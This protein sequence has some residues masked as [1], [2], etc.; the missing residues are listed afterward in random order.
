[1]TRTGLRSVLVRLK[2][3]TMWATAVAVLSLA[4]ASPAAAQVE[5][6]GVWQP[7]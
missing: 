7:R 1:M 5:L 6:S 4:A 3:D 2:A